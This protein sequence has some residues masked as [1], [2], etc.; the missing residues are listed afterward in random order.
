MS[1]MKT[2]NE[3]H[4]VLTDMLSGI[5]ANGG[6]ATSEGTSLA[7]HLQQLETLRVDLA[8]EMPNMLA[9]YLEKRSYTKALDFLEGRDEAEAPNC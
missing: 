5:A 4:Q 7:A 9:H 3:L 6:S 2:M 1:E 8:G